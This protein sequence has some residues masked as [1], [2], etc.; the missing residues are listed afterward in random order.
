MAQRD[1]EESKTGGAEGKVTN[2]VDHY[3]LNA[4]AL[5]DLLG[6]FKP[7]TASFDPNGNWENSYGILCLNSGPAIRVGTLRLSRIAGHGGKFRLDVKRQRDLS[8]QCREVTEAQI[9]CAGDE[10]STP[11][12]WDYTCQI[13]DKED[14]SQK[15]SEIKKSA[16]IKN[17]ALKITVN[18][19]QVDRAT[20]NGAATIDW[21]L[22]DAVQRRGED[23]GGRQTFNL[24]EQ[25][26]ICKAN[27][28]LSYRKSVRVIPANPI[29]L[30]A[31]DHIG[32]GIAPWVYWVDASGRLL[33]AVSGVQAYVIES[34]N[35]E[36]VQGVSK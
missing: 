9:H 19:K 21:C 10:L 33:F 7:L 35:G 24:I 30:R 29:T 3:P 23:G 25:F 28:M 11:S 12:H 8:G 22:F 6:A 34:S 36:K 16:V 26:D 14:Q 17:S 13:L 20:L 15:I 18:V 27:Q 31:Y 2:L 1:G 4:P 5:K 32:D